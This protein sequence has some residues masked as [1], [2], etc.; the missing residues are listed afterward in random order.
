M[1]VHQVV[2]TDARNEEMLGY[3]GRCADAASGEDGESLVRS[4]DYWSVYAM[5]E[6][7]V[8]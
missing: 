6:P 4:I 3:V 5:M 1:V 7:N 8:L 2:K